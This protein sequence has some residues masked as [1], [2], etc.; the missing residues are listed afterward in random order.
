MWW[1][2]LA[3]SGGT[4]LLSSIFGKKPKAMTFAEAYG[5]LP[6]IPTALQTYKPTDFGQMT[7]LLYKQAEKNLQQAFKS[8]SQ[9]IME[10]AA[11]RGTYQSG[12]PSLGQSIMRGQQQQAL[13]QVG[14]QLSVQEMQQRA[15]EQESFRNRL[16]QLYA[17]RLSAAGQAAGMQTGVAQQQYGQQ[18][19]GLQ[20]LG[21]AG[22]LLS[23]LL[24]YGGQQNPGEIPPWLTMGV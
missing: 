17:S 7:D 5:Q 8:G 24:R 9:Q 15:A 10:Q 3:V 19:A 2:P 14:T 1:L 4:S 13:G 22:G 23:M 12:L 20:G 6:P 21:E 18:L 16:A 11:A